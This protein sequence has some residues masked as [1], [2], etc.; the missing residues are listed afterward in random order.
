MFS[1]LPEDLMTILF[2]IQSFSATNIKENGNRIIIEAI[3]TV[4]SRCPVC[5]EAC[6]KT[7]DSTTQEILIGNVLGKA[8]Y[9]SI[10]V[11]RVI[12]PTCGIKTEENGI[13]KG[14]RR[15]SKA[16]EVDVIKHTELLDN[17][18]AGSLMG[19]SRSTVYRIDKEKLGDL[20]KKYR[21]HIPPAERISVD[22]YARKKGHNYATAVA[23]Y[24]KGVVLWVEEGRKSE[25]LERAYD[26]LGESL[27][28]VKQVS[29][30]LW[31]AYEK[32]TVK[33]LPEA[34]I[35]YDRFH[36]SR[37]L[38]R[39]VEEERRVYQKQ[40][41]DEE[42]RKMK[43][44]SRWILLKRRDNL[45]KGNRKHLEEL[46]KRNTALYE[47][48]LLK[49]EFLS[50]FE[51]GKSPDDAKAEITAWIDTVLETNYEKLKTF[52]RSI[53]K[54]LLKVVNWFRNPISNGKMEGINNKIKTVMR[55]AYGYK[56]F[57]YMRLK[58]L[59]K[60][61]LL[62]STFPYILN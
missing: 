21:A 59:Q 9:C 40:L 15:H 46:K 2:K 13:S 48:Y 25:D 1:S 33:K 51:E 44:H 3:K 41:S 16:V 24:D 28:G 30:D 20:F 39:A 34:Q 56:D 10:K 14:K 37:L 19:L 6:E 23:D 62:M 4:P 8:V 35:V 55:R 12:C 52:A 22:E 45:S 61:G 43:K 7:K 50:L 36:I 49:E 29:V 32:A 31:P 60:C 5:G 57:E 17:E 42:R 27:K 54:R 58:V 47:V 18:S 11:K 26:N 38:N 53:Y